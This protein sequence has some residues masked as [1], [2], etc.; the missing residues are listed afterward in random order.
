DDGKVP[1]DDKL[2]AIEIFSDLAAIA[3]QNAELYDELDKD[4]KKIELLID[5]IGHD[6]NNYV[7]AVSGFLELAMARKGVPEPSRK[8]M[9]KAH[10]QVLNLNRLVSNV[11]LYAKVE[12]VGDRD[13]RAMDLVRAIME[14]FENAETQSPGRQVKLRFEDDGKPKLAVMNDLAKEVFFNLFTNAIKFDTHEKVVIDVDISAA[15]EDRRDMWCVSVSDRGQGIEDELKAEVFDRFKQG[16]RSSL[17][18]GLGLHIA[19]T[20]V[21]YYK[22]RVWV[23]DRIPGDRTQGSVFKVMLPKDK[24]QA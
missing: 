10:D 13:L 15:C 1:D 9:A 24:A 20:L 14:A 12:S 19:K 18:S 23:E 2:R 16:S 8:S 21:G 6:V 4:R 22:G 17:G 5:L 7:Q 3:I 11:K